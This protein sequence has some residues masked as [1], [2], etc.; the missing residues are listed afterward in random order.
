[1]PQMRE[2]RRGG[3]AVRLQPAPARPAGPQVGPPW[4]NP[5]IGWQCHLGAAD[6]GAATMSAP[7][8][9]VDRSVERQAFELDLKW[10]ERNPGRTYHL[11]RAL[12][13]EIVGSCS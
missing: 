4:R 10:F 6:C 3:A 11:R 1:M 12:P 13:G 8:E 7:A 2:R 5:L 9:D